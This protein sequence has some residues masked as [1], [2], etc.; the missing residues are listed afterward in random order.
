MHSE[1]FAPIVYVLKA[2]NVKEAIQWNNEVEQGLSSSIFTQNLSTIFEVRTH[3]KRSQNLLNC[4][5]FSG[6]DLKVQIVVS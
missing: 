5:V 4:Y 2:D 1:C 6:L 3:V